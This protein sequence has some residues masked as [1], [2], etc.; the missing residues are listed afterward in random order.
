MANLVEPRKFASDG[1][2]PAPLPG[3]SA[4]VRTTLIHTIVPPLQ[5]VVHVRLTRTSLRS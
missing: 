1:I 3:P 4:S 5:L 2:P